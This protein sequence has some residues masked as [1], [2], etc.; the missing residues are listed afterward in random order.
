MCVVSEKTVVLQNNE[1][2]RSPRDR[3]AIDTSL[4]LQSQNDLRTRVRG[5]DSRFLRG[6]DI[7]LT[8]ESAQFINLVPCGYTHDEREDARSNNP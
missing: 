5:R 7:L 1:Q 2:T 3:V 4:Q 6:N 8:G